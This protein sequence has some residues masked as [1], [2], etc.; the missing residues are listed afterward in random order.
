MMVSFL[1]GNY[2]KIKCVLMCL[3]LFS[4]ARCEKLVIGL[5]NSNES[6][7]NKSN[8][9]VCCISAYNKIGINLNLYFKIIPF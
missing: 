1:S 4:A 8:V 2:M 3:V 7:C 5:G 9:G 6:D